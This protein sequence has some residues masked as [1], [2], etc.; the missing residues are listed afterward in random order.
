[1]I[2]T[3]SP[4]NG[5]VFDGKGSKPVLKEINEY[6]ADRYFIRDVAKRE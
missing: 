2:D 1:L 4:G 6:Y 3:S 5:I